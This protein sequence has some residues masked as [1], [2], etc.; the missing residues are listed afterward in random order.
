MG[1]L[2][3]PATATDE[4]A[5]DVVPVVRELLAD[6]TTPVT[7]FTRL[8]DPDRPG[9]LLEGVS[10]DG[11]VGRYSYISHRPRVLPL[12]PGDP[13][14]ALH[15]L[16]TSRVAPVPG[17]PPFA[18]GAVGYLGYDVARHFERL[19]APPPPAEGLPD[20]AFLAVDDLAVLDHATRRLLLV[21][22]HRPREESRA[23][24]LAR[25]DAMQ[26]RIA[27][28][29]PEPAP[30]PAGPPAE[31][32]PEVDR[33]TFTARVRQAKE[34]I[35]AGE[36]FQIVVSQR[37]GKP[38]RAHP[39]TVYRHLRAV[40]PSPYMY[41]LS[42]GEGRYVVGASPELLVRTD[43]RQVRIRPLAG[44]RPRG[45]DAPA[46][47]ALER[48]LL[49]DEKERAEHV[50]LVDLARNDLSRVCRPGTVEVERMLDVERFSHVMHLS[51]T[52]VGELAAPHTCLDAI[53][54]AFP[55]GTLS[56]AP[57]IR[58]MELIAEL[59][60]AGRGVYGG[61]LG[62]VGHGGVADLAIALRTLVVSDG[63]VHV[64]AGA[65]VVADSDPDAEYRETVHKA[66]AVFAAVRAAE[67]QA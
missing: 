38:L 48:E 37:F 17:L 55:A 26:A 53:R 13:L 57:K 61:A 9:F 62:F 30:E 23:D 59:E 49:A 14:A 40:N 21:T 33:A 1:E 52:V 50:M 29:A 58:A 43:G 25:L 41:H 67:E 15:P 54:C 10:P 64:R 27:A 36:A 51:S 28:P 12:P 63:T 20:A 18:G 42:L 7:L 4:T 35:A 39:L 32:E 22:L 3:R 47:T 11:S 34:H 2:T 5:Y 56:G 46:D 19:P 66:G 60:G 44:T 65:G 31:W 16:V 6:T 24:A 8:N 45:A